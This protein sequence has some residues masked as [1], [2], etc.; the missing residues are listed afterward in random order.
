A[1]TLGAATLVLGRFVP[2][3]AVPF[4][5][6]TW[7]LGDTTGVMVV[8]PLLLAWCQSP[9]FLAGNRRFAEA[10]LLFGLLLSTSLIVFG[11]R[12]VWGEGSARLTHLASPYRV[13]A[14]FRVGERG[15]ARALAL[16]TAV[17]VWS[18]AQ[19]L[20]PFVHMTLQESLLLLQIFVAVV[21]VTALGIA[22]VL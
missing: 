15:A 14:A 12:R 3:A 7:W 5:W 13:W 2:P 17:A 10:G 18:T 19:G 20:G 11:G 6:W 22:A 8:T 9:P 4:V 21:T 16:L 1:S